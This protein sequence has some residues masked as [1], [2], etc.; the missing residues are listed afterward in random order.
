MQPV[1]LVALVSSALPVCVL[2]QGTRLFAVGT[3][4]GVIRDT[5]GIPQMGA[6]VEAVLPDARVAGSAITDSRGGYHFLLE[7]GSYRI[8]AT[9]ALLLPAVRE[10]LQIAGGTRTIVNLTLSTILAPGGWL[11]VARRTTSEPGDDWKWTLRSS[12]SRPI[13]RFNDS[14]SINST[15]PDEAT[16]GVSSS[17]QE[18]RRGATSGRLTLRDDEGRFAHGGNHNLMVLTRVN[19]DG[20]GA[21]LHADLSGS[22]SPYPVAPSAEISVGLQRKTMLNGFS[23]AVLSYSAHPELVNSRGVTG[24]QSMTL[25]SGQRIDFGDL[26]RIDVGSVVR[27]SN[28]GGNVL[29][30]EPF[31]RVAAH[32]GAE[33]VL[34]YTMTR[35]RGTES[36]EDLD[37]VQAPVALAVVKGNRLRLEGGSHHALSATGRLP[38]GGVAEFSIYHDQL[39]NPLVSG[40]GMLSPADVQIDGLVADPTTRTY[41]VGV[42]DYSGSGVRVML[43]Q[44]LTKSLRAGT[45]FSTGRALKASAASKAVSMNDLLDGSAPAKAYAATAFVD[46]KI[47]ATGTSLRASYRWQPH[48]TLTAVDAFRMDE[49]GAFLSCSLHQSLGSLHFLPHGLEAVVD[50]QNLLSE[51]YQPFLSKDGKT[52]YLAQTPHSVQ[53][54]VSFSF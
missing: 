31:L 52:L 42:R 40:S 38:G 47:L 20:S 45:E 3:L 18:A 12:A 43:S 25:R 48:R 15:N 44:P 21:V 17:R 4:S 9:A 14:V 51:G 39:R 23:R 49:E 19:E 6:L 46:G 8:R 37:R 53:A 24:L 13:L 27:D 1:F 11:P 22:R 28:L 2:G 34:A 5:D 30:V 10:R 33:V 36:L 7:P 16:L 50:V 32:P 29:A 54:G 35:S 26:I 41:R